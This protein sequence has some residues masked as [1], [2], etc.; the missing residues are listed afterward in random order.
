[1]GSHNWAVTVMCNADFY[2]SNFFLREKHEE[3]M[4]EEVGDV[5]VMFGKVLDILFHW[6]DYKTFIN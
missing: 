1:M 5:L 2:F 3:I 4:T 6:R